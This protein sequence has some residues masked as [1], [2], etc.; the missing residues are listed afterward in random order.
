MLQQLEEYTM[1][2]LGAG[3]SGRMSR[4]QLSNLGLWLAW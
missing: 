1:H 2:D 4:G 3:H